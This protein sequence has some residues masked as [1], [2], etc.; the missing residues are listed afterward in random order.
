MKIS[1][2][3]PTKDRGV[4]L[5]E[6]IDAI[7]AQTHTDWELIIKESGLGSGY[8]AV[9]DL[10]SDK[11]ITY[12]YSHDTGISQ[13]FNTGLKL[14][15]G[16]IFNWANDDDLLLPNA[17]E[18]VVASI[19][20]KKWL[21]GKIACFSKDKRVGEMGYAGT[22]QQLKTGNFV[23]QPSVFWTREAFEKIGYMNEG[24]R[25]AQDYEYWLKLMLEYPD[26]VFVDRILA[27]Y[28]FHPDQM[29]SLHQ[30]E[31]VNEARLIAQSL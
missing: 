9:K 28:R 17:F 8:S 24:L 21:Y 30:T 1:V 12:V 23:P 2:I 31:Q 25:Y 4:Y 18:T 15:V 19:G 14:A 20:E 10:L 3:M 22:V 16:E 7:L 29:S 26:Y 11:R 5:R 13:A 6:A 27:R